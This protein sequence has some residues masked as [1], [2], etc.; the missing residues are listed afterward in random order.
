MLKRG[1]EKHPQVV[2]EN[3]LSAIALVHVEINN[4]HFFQAV[5]FECVGCANRDVVVEAEPHRTAAFGV[6]TRGP[7]SAKSRFHLAACYQVNSGNRRPGSTSGGL[8]GIRT[9]YGVGIDVRI[10]AVRDHCS[11][12]VEMVLRM[13]SQK[14][15]LGH[16]RRLTIAKHIRKPAAHEMILD[17]RQASDRLRMTVTRIMPVTRRVADVGG[18]Q[19]GI[20]V[21]KF[22]D[23]PV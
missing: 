19:S 11:H 7:D 12:I 20:P 5:M 23:C 15:S 14:L 8:Q 3:L 13:Y 2:F 6:M 22:R 9:D 16:L 4:C 1:A 10:T 21:L 17:R 18:R